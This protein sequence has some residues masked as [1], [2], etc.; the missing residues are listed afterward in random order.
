MNTTIP[1]G[2]AQVRIF[3]PDK[4]G[5]YHL[6]R[7]CGFQVRAMRHVGAPVMEFNRLCLKCLIKAGRNSRTP[8][9]YKKLLKAQVS[10]FGYGIIVTNVYRSDLQ[11]DSYRLSPRVGLTSLGTKHIRIGQISSQS[12]QDITEDW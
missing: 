2:S 10:K 6:Q 1:Q 5:R 12:L 8:G 7:R 3:G 9:W 4:G 11:P